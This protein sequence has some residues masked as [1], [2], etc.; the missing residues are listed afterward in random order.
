MI[1]NLFSKDD[2][3]QVYK[4]IIYASKIRPFI[5]K[6][7]GDLWGK[8]GPTEI[9]VTTSPFTEYLYRRKIITIDSLTNWPRLT[10]SIEE[11]EIGFSPNSIEAAIKF[12]DLDR[13]TELSTTRDI[14][15][16][17]KLYRETVHPVDFAA[18]FGSKKIFQ[19]LLLNGCKISDDTAKF[20]VKGGNIEIIEYSLQNGNQITGLLAIAIEYH[21]NDVVNWLLD[22]GSE[23]NISLQHCIT[24]YNTLS[25]T[26]FFVNN[27]G[28]ND[29]VNDYSPLLTAAEGGKGDIVR[30]LISNGA[31][32][33][34]K[35]QYGDSPFTRA[36]TNCHFGVL[37][38]LIDAGVDV[39]TKYA[40]GTPVISR[41]AN[42]GVIKLVK[43]LLS[44]GV[45]IK[46]LNKEDS[47]LLMLASSSGH[48]DLV[49]YLIDNGA[50]LY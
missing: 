5:W 37:K 16:D 13:I 21:R 40:D 25:F 22:N 1:Q 14:C 41:A 26:Y 36:A 4:L 47:S 15:V 27:G 39:N 7:L 31:D 10:Y 28:V 43:F 17:L 9:R 46:T 20:A 50:D 33:N 18:F 29:E 19:Y 38:Q 34:Y 6:L 30:F 42:D 12:D 23:E 3:D 32:C 45:D 44:E 24:Y 49:Q 35:N 11:F 2:Y 48:L 8:L